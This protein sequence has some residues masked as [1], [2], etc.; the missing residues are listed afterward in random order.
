MTGNFALRSAQ[1]RYLQVQEARGKVHVAVE[2]RRGLCPSVGAGLIR[3]TE[4]GTG[5]HRMAWREVGWQA[6]G[7]HQ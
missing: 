6:R 7:L 4:Q 3:R 2:G 5:K 1:P